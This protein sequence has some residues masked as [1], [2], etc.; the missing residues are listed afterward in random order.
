MQ[1]TTVANSKT[2]KHGCFFFV[3]LHSIN[4]EIIIRTMGYDTWIT[5]ASMT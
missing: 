4:F 3:D 2:P 1:Y 5:F